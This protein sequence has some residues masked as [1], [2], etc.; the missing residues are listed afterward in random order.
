MGD[1]EHFV[2]L[3]R[4]GWFGYPQV[5]EVNFFFVSH[6]RLDDG[7]VRLVLDRH[8]EV[9]R[10]WYYGAFNIPTHHCV[11]KEECRYFCVHGFPFGYL[12]VNL[13]SVHPFLA[14][15]PAKIVAYL[16]Y[17]CQVFA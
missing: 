8:S 6:E 10:L 13:L 12:V 11:E 5:I 15:F 4:I 16:S 3:A 2:V 14:Y 1:N 17:K 9:F 7:F